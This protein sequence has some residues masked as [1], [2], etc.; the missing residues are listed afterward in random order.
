MSELGTLSKEDTRMF[1]NNILQSQLGIYCGKVIRSASLEHRTTVF[2][3]HLA[4]AAN[5]LRMLNRLPAKY[6]VFEELEARRGLKVVTEMFPQITERTE[7]GWRELADSTWEVVQF[8][9]GANPPID[10][11]LFGHIELIDALTDGRAQLHS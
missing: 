7:W 2:E 1:A 6:V 11:G 9:P 5:G 10:Q 4:L 3:R 8:T